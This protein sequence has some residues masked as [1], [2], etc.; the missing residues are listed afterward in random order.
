M[1]T[2]AVI[3]AGLAFAACGSG[4]RSTIPADEICAVTVEAAC[5][6]EIRCGRY[7][8]RA[9]CVAELTDIFDACPL[10]VHAI[11]LQEVGYDD[12]AA[13]RFINAVRAGS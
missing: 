1:R 6:R 12:A 13:A 5:D 11:A 2:V 10:T 8:D 9:G 7:A 4:T 3:A